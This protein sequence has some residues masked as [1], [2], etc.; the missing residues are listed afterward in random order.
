MSEM[1]VVSVVIPT[2]NR[3]SLAGRAVESVLAQTFQDF[4]II[5]VDDGSNDN[6]ESVVKA[7]CDPR[8]RYIHHEENRG[9]SAARNTGIKAAR[10]AYIA[11]LDSDDEWLPEKLQ[12]QLDTLQELPPCWGGGCTGF[13]LVEGTSVVE[14]TPDL[15]PNLSNWL[16][17]H[18]PLSAGSTLMVRKEILG[19]IGYF[20]ES[21]PR[22]QDWDLLLRLAE[23]YKLA[24]VKAPL[25]K[26]H[27]GDLPPADKVREAKEKLLA[28]YK[29]RIDGLS[30]FKRRQV[31]ASHWLR[32][33]TLYFGERRF[34][35]GGEF[36]IRAARGNPLQRPGLYI[37]LVDAILGTHLARRLSAVKWGILGEVKRIERKREGS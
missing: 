4:E 26:R 19:K 28:K 2:Y 34:K 6:T 29:S 25:V 35:K 15:P 24:M 18:C 17:A 9:G 30:V 33:A 13:W 16:L 27:V 5:V 12:S 7:F 32:L 22:H 14:R 31:I 23:N 3:G 1:P 20:D 10:G 37:S 11:F 8:V 21:L 36:L